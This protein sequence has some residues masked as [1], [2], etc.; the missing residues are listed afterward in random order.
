[1]QDLATKA[2]LTAALD[3]QTLKFTLLAGLSFGALL[4]GLMAVILASA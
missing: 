3:A 2:D 1:M 4:V